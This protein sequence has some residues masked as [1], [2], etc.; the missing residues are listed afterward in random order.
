MCQRYHK[1]LNCRIN[2]NNN[3]RSITWMSVPR[4]YRFVPSDGS[5]SNRSEP[6]ANDRRPPRSHHRQQELR[7][8]LKWLKSR[9]KVPRCSQIS[10][11]RAV[12]ASGASSKQRP[13]IECHRS[14]SSFQCTMPSH[15]SMNV[16][17]RLPHNATEVE[18]KCLCTMIAALY[19]ACQGRCHSGLVG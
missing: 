2:N 1:N 11:Y 14:R 6:I 17:T 7:Y 9:V 5:A 19:V 8:P 18:C 12:Y 10:L 16:Y 4:R 3:S 15:G 13:T